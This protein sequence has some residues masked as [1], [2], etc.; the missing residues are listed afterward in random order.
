VA[1]IPVIRVTFFMFVNVRTDHQITNSPLHC[2]DL[3][4]AMTQLSFTLCGM[5]I[6]TAFAHELERQARHESRKHSHTQR[7]EC[8]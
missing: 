3:N 8:L 6:D 1:L 7:S 2:N 4:I 5:Q